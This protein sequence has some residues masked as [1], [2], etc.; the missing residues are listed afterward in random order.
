MPIFRAFSGL[1]AMLRPA[2]VSLPLLLLATKLW[3]AHAEHPSATDLAIQAMLVLF[4]AALLVNV[5]ISVVT[6]LRDREA[7]DPADRGAS[8]FTSEL[9]P[10]RPARASPPSTAAAVSE[11]PS[12]RAPPKQVLSER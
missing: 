5:I 2:V 1:T 10:Q 8:R 12:N 7:P 6:I 3:A 11:L 9:E 4:M